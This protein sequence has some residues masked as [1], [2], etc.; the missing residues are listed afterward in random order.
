M[1]DYTT[2][3]VKVPKKKLI[4]VKRLSDRRYLV[5]FRGIRRNS[6]LPAKGAYRGKEGAF[7]SPEK[8]Q[9]MVD[10]YFA[11]CNGP[12]MDKW[13][14]LIRDKQGELVIMQNRPYTV[15][16]LALHLGLPTASFCAYCAGV[17]DEITE[18]ICEDRLLSNILN[19]ARQ[20][21]NEYA[22][23]RLYDREGQF[24]A[25]FVLD[26]AFGWVGSKEMAEI[27]EKRAMM[28][29]RER[30]FNLK[31]RLYEEGENPDSNITVNIVRATKQ[32]ED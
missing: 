4:R 31:Q 21:I 28:M 2:V 5:D 17:F 14:N 6:V 12:V 10:E 18:D 11:S 15:S 20:R 8:L 32:E 26:R 16:G 29:L 13:G 22:E 30:E 19:K 25:K 3:T 23:T 9:E 27:V 24:G 7:S 1:S